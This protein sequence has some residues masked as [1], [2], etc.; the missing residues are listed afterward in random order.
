MFFYTLY[1]FEISFGL[2]CQPGKLP[3]YSNFRINADFRNRVIP[4]LGYT[5]L[6]LVSLVNSVFIPKLESVRHSARLTGCQIN[7]EKPL[8]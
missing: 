8:L 2:G 7:F 4:N 3:N 6:K 5:I 1:F